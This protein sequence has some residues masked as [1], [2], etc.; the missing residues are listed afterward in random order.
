MAGKVGSDVLCEHGYGASMVNTKGGNN[1]Q[2]VVLVI[3]ASEGV[4][5]YLCACREHMFVL[6][7][8]NSI[9]LGLLLHLY[10]CNFLL[11]LCILLHK[12]HYTIK[13]GDDAPLCVY[14]ALLACPGLLC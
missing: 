4:S 1:V 6:P 5:K 11:A 13:G 10:S 2:E 8:M 14:F 12:Q 3:V 9:C 7:R